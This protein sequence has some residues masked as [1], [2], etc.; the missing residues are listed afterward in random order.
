MQQKINI[1]KVTISSDNRQSKPTISDNQQSKLQ[2][3]TIT[4]LLNSPHFVYDTITISADGKGV[5][6]KL[7]GVKFISIMA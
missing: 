5:A 1:L 7:K 6:E 2:S 4:N 3:V